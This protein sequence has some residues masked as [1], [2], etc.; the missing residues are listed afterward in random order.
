MTVCFEGM[1]D[2]CDAGVGWDKFNDLIKKYLFIRRKTLNFQ[3]PWKKYMG[4]KR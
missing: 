4:E 3:R 1:R 2:I